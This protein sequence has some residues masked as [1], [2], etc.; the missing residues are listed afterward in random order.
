MNA[1]AIALTPTTP[2]RSF[3][4][5]ARVL[6]TQILYVAPLLWL[7]ELAQNQAWKAVN[8]TYGWL[9]P[10]SPYG[11]FSFGSMVLWVG[12]VF[13]MWTMHYY[14]FH[15]RQLKAWARVGIGSVVCWVGEWIGGFM[16]VA[17]TGKHLHVWPGATLVYVSGPAIFFWVSNVIVYHLLTVHVIDLTPRY[18][19][20]ADE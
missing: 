5:Y 1:N 14:W 12:S 17:L 16:A 10:D 18:D 3:G 19:V 13:L 20:P 2:H 7:L 9:Y 8:G 15:P 6:A 11:W 4:V